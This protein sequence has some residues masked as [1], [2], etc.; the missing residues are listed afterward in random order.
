[1]RNPVTSEKKMKKARET[2]ELEEPLGIIISR[3][4]RDEVRPVFAGYVWGP[5]PEPAAEISTK[6]A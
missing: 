3:G 2:P 1:V 6:V 5:V 4:N